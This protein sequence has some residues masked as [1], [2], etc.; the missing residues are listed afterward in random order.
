[1][2]VARIVALLRELADV[3]EEEEPPDRCAPP[4]PGTAGKRVQRRRLPAVPANTNISPLDR[5]A[6]RR[7]LKRAGFVEVK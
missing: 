3:L 2:N 6:A 5:A 7:H 4:T 1:V